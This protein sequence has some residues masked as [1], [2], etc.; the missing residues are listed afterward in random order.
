[1]PPRNQSI[2]KRLRSHAQKRLVFDPGIPRN[3]Q[4]SSYKRYLE[5]ENKMLKRWHLRG[6]P[7][8]QICQ[9]RA[10]MID[11]VIENLFLSAL[12]L[13]L[14]KYDKLQ[15]R[16]AVVAT[17]GY[18]RAELN[19]HS[20]I[21]IMFLYPDDTESEALTQFQELMAEEILYPLWDLG[22]KVG[23]ASR[24]TKE[25]LEEI[26][27]EIQS[28]NAILESRFICG[29]QP[30]FKEMIRGFLENI[31]QDQSIQ[32]IEQRLKNESDRH[33]KFGKTLYVQEP[34]IK[35]GLGGLRDYQNILWIAKIKFGCHSFRDL[36]KRKL[37]RPDEQRDI[38]KA[39]D[40]LLRV[41]NE[42]HYQNKWPTDKIALEQQLKI[43]T[44]LNY[45]Q[46][47]S[48]ARLTALMQDYYS[49][50]RT[51]YSISELLKE[52]FFNI[53][54]N[55]TKRFS[56][57]DA[58]KA[59]Q[60]KSI[61]EIDG[62]L[63]HKGVLF[64]NKND[65]FS[66]DP[67]R[68]IRV[69]RIK[70]QFNV[71][72]DINLKNKIT[73][74]IPL[75]DN[76]VINSPDT[77]DSFK[78]I[79]NAPGEVYPI[80]KEMHFLGVLGRYIPEFGEL[81]CLIQHEFYHRYTAD[82]H[83]LRTIR[84]LDNVF[85]KKSPMDVPYEKEIRKN[86]KP[87]LLYIT[88]LL[89]DIGKSGGIRGHAESGAILAEPI[90]NRLG[91]KKEDQ[92]KILFIIRKHL[93]M[94]RFWQRYDLD[95]IQTAISFSEIIKDKELLRL[96]TV[97]TYCDSK[98]TAPTMWNNYK[99]SMHQ[100]LFSKTLEILETQ[101]CPDTLNKE[102]K[103]MLKKD[104]L[105]LSLGNLPEEEVEA[106][107]SLLPERYFVNTSANEAILHLNM[108][109]RLLS[110]IQNA[111]SIGSLSPIIDWRD[112]KNLGMSVINIVT[113]DRAGLFYK[114][115]GALTLS[116]LAIISTRAISRK[117]H[118]SIDTFYV[119]DLDGKYVSDPKV[120]ETFKEKVEDVL[121]R[122]KDLADEIFALEKKYLQANTKPI[123]LPS[124]FP[125]SVEVY[126]ELSLHRT[127]IEVQAKDQIAL[128]FK[129]TQL[130][131]DKGF[132]ISF[133][134]IATERG[135]AMDTFYI[136]NINL[137]ESTNTSDLLDLRS[138]IEMII[139]SNE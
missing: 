100:T 114:L 46:R 53:E 45:T 96:L 75:I 84:H 66:K 3:Q 12:D 11:V 16:M 7:G 9:M 98:G 136:E 34:D 138:D 73:N 49:A 86:N 91:Y 15:F 17:G 32:Y 139:K 30:L 19:P 55:K 129:I 89:H 74:S 80:L 61:K 112:D 48:F 71:S 119:V 72:L 99:D 134:R 22:L 93:E 27:K 102:Y 92:K 111:D 1:M 44:Q 81:T 58:L 13:Y 23:H 87:H 54:K 97:H 38:E 14:T 125:P 104:V 69:F 137:N 42:L 29:S 131:T 118:I 2:L 52:R 101:A 33:L 88:L 6:E 78:A 103:A 18:G 70:Q 83:V 127:I 63:I 107:F 124:P 85:A 135:I 123:K 21:D 40:F 35:N 62:F 116:E 77:A 67:N 113:W 37:L 28:K 115:A 94:A 10:M 105:Q 128:L 43:A 8:R 50:A 36:A 90:L 5:L 39:Y 25:V 108:I 65:I 76:H 41:R 51:I 56:F 31:K 126:H 117:D 95:D 24:N 59:H 130:I 110:Q 79:L 20:D 122:G 106:H 68:L 57:L 133:A 4:L 64:S 60:K 120:K 121:V 132:D 109:N 47:D 82:E 26:N